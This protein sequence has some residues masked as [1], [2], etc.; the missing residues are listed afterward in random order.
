MATRSLNKVELD[1]LNNFG[2]GAIINVTTVADKLNVSKEEVR[3]AF[4]YLRTHG[5]M[6]VYD[7]PRNL[8]YD[9]GGEWDYKLTT[10]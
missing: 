3:K 6:E 1:I 9:G 10:K 7:I 5:F 4:R 2:S 8:T